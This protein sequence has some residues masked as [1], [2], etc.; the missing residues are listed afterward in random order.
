ML[1]DEMKENLLAVGQDFGEIA[2]DAFMND[3]IWKDIPVISTAVNIAKIGATFRDRAFLNKL[4]DFLYEYEKLTGE[5]KEKIK[6]KI[7][8][9]QDKKS[10][11]EEITKTIDDAENCKKATL[12]GKA[13]KALLSDE[14]D[15]NLYL[16]LANRISK[17]YYSDIL[18]LKDFET[19]NS[20]YFASNDKIPGIF[21]DQLYFC[22]FLSDTGYSG[23]GFNDE[24]CG[25]GY[26]LNEYGRALRKILMANDE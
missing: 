7:Y 13:M 17:C 26:A 3:G 19:E 25:R 9:Y 16:V 15:V 22:G 23:G 18:H 4:H 1:S 20:E 6:D 10:F 21:L 11:G 8:S 2:I 14:V 5:E 24:P 12:L